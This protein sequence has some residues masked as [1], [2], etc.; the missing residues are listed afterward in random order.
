MMGLETLKNISKDKKKEKLIYILI[1][2]I[3]LFIASSYIFKE[4]KKVIKNEEIKVTNN[5]LEEK[6]SKTLSDISGVNDVSVMIT[7][8]NE[9]KINPVYNITEEEKNGVKLVNKQVV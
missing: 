1:I 2:A 8:S 3:I 7:Y 5:N 9:N 4:D 6:L